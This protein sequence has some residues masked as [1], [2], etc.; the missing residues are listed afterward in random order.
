MI[1]CQKL[2][3]GFSM[4]CTEISRIYGV[5]TILSYL[6]SILYT[7]LANKIWRDFPW[8]MQM[9]ALMG[10]SPIVVKDAVYWILIYLVKMAE[11]MWVSLCSYQVLIYIIICTLVVLH[12]HYGLSKIIIWHFLNLMKSCQI[13]MMKRIQMLLV[14]ESLCQRHLVQKSSPS[15]LHHHQLY[16]T[17][18]PFQWNEVQNAKPWQ[19][20]LPKL[21]SMNGSMASRLR[22]SML[23][24]KLNVQSNMRRFITNQSLSLKRLA[25]NSKPRRQRWYKHTN[26]WWWISKLLLSMLEL[27]VP[28]LALILVFTKV[29]FIISLDVYSFSLSPISY[30]ITTIYPSK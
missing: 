25:Y 2:D 13:P 6:G 10:T 8:Y 16:L 9:H 17:H 3:K 29:L 5:S 18:H 24:Q 15:S 26:L 14:M 4:R 23:R 12:W 28:S 11:E 1:R 20:N 7:W 22:I 21:L 30:L 19:I 27:V